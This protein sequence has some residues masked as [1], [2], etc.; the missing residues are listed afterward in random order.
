MTKMENVPITA[1]TGTW[2]GDRLKDIDYLL[3]NVDEARHALEVV[4]GPLPE[5][6]M[7]ATLAVLHALQ[8][9][10]ERAC[11]LEAQAEASKEKHE[12]EAM[13]KKMETSIAETSERRKVVLRGLVEDLDNA[14]LQG[15]LQELSAKLNESR[16]ALKQLEEPACVR[17]AKEARK[18]AKACATAFSILKWDIDFDARS[19]I[20]KAYDETWKPKMRRALEER[21]GTGK[22]RAKK[23]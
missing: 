4:P 17:G 22:K 15:Q 19:T 16:A 3:W 13:K 8:R 11:T 7:Q 14:A 10:E 9:E 1:H 6:R 21:M 5:D 23:A 12:Y 18:R 20:E 2:F